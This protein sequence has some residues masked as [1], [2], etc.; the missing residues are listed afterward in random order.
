MPGKRIKR[1]YTEADQKCASEGRVPY[2]TKKGKTGCRKKPSKSANPRKVKYTLEH[3]QEKAMA[4][5][6]TY[7][8][9][10][11]GHLK[12][13]SLAAKLRNHGIAI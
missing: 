4:N 5:G 6:I 2:R 1:P 7:S 8:K 9:R 3:L 11:G 12:K 13:S 10:G